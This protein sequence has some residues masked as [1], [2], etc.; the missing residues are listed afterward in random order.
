MDTRDRKFAGSV[1]SS[2]SALILAVVLTS[3]LAIVGILF[4]MMARVDK[5]ATS[6]I[7]EN[8]ELNLAVETVIAGISQ[9]LVSDIP[10]VAGHEYYDYPDVNNIWLASLE[11]RLN[12]GGTPAD[13]TDDI[14]YWR[15]V[16]DITGYLDP[17]SRDVPAV[18]LADHVRIDPCDLRADA[19]GDGI[20]DSL[21]IRLPDMTSSKGEPIYA[22]VRIVDNQA[23]LNVNSGFKFDP[24]AAEPNRIDGSSQLQINLMALSWRPGFTVYDLLDEMDLLL[25]RANFGVGVADPCDLRAYERDVIWRYGRPNG[26][27][28]PFDISDELEM[29][30]RYLL[31]HT[32]IDTRLE[33]WG[34]E[35][36]INTFWRPVQQPV[37]L[38][39]WFYSAYYDAGMPDPNY[40]Y[41]H[42]ATTYNMDRIID[43]NGEMMINVN[44]ETFAPKI[45]D[46][47]LRSMD[48]VIPDSITR[49]RFVQL[50][51][52][53][54][55]FVDNDVNVTT[56]IDPCGTYYGFDG[57][58]FINEIAWK[59]GPSP[60]V[61]PNFFALELY[62][63]FDRDIDLGDYVLEFINRNDPADQYSITFP[64]G[65][66]IEANGYFVI[67]NA[68]VFSIYND[69]NTPRTIR[70][71]PAL[72]FF[73]GWA[74]SNLDKSRPPVVT[75][76]NLDRSK[77]PITEDGAW[78]S[79]YDMSLKRSVLVPAPG[80][81]I[82]VD[83]QIIND[84]NALPGTALA[85]GRDD[86]D[87]RVIYQ[88]LALDGAY[89]GSLGIANYRHIPFYDPCYPYPKHLYSFFLPNPLDPRAE[90]ITVGDIPRL[91]TLG[92]GTTPNSSIGRQL[93]AYEMLE[94]STLVD[95]E[96]NVRLDLQNPLH[97]NV[98][99]YLTV[100]DPNSDNIDNDADGLT[101]VADII[102]P[103]VQIPGRIN[104]NTAPWYVLAQL[105]W[106]SP[107]TPNYELARTIVDHRD[108]VGGFRSTGELN[109]VGIADPCSFRSI[110]YY[111]RTDGQV[112]DLLG[113]PDLTFA[114]DIPDDFEERDVIFSRISNLVSVR[115]DVFTAYIL[116]RIGIDGPQ[117]RIVAILDRSGVNKANVSLPDG[118][119]RIVALHYVP[120]PR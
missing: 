49:R 114:D 68:N 55:D 100:F 71:R 84:S 106:V 10:G 43:P 113:F 52:N 56:F 74:S 22:A 16:S 76:P 6:A 59:I 36:R 28:T 1:F 41:R 94:T 34:G 88:T 104:I 75:N 98:F 117:K 7:P 14:Y 35:F 86:R 81:M 21:W 80:T 97:R 99:Q 116:V 83:N 8:R 5:V 85:F 3:M 107:H 4:V 109:F 69:P 19:D 18:V 102:S 115:S 119:V 92:H 112:G 53:M 95:Q 25:S 51:V 91:L 15:Q 77:P 46:R 37:N 78:G 96:H 50:T 48:P 40:A 60:G 31:N 70:V 67:V 24:T 64:F 89:G 13:L 29:R 12:D 73:E 42:L 2:G 32:G 33:A 38:I 39:D 9:Q 118:K 93:M 72:R 103:E 110:D 65:E 105:P 44:R 47:L 20:A 66:F 62:N 58:P 111:A 87:W 101:D 79:V 54:A 11:P 108:I 30:Y 57:Q 27:Y 61:T 82:Y 17:L 45:Y 63:P 120:D 90:F 23:M 26:P